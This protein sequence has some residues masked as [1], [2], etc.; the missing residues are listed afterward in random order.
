MNLVDDEELLAPLIFDALIK[1]WPELFISA[2]EILDMTQMPEP[3]VWEWE[4]P[5]R[6]HLRVL[7]G[8]PDVTAWTADAA[9]HLAAVL[10]EPASAHRTLLGL[11]DDQPPTV[12]EPVCAE[13][14][15]DTSLL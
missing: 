3:W 5:L 8:R 15:E 7:G 10:K 11:V 13:G 9:L 14:E 12:D 4:T 2:D 6:A 1:E